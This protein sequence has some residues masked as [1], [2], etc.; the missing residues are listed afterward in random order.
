MLERVFL[1]YLEDQEKSIKERSGFTN[2]EKK[3]MLLSSETRTGLI[4]TSMS[5]LYV[6]HFYKVENI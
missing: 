6:S 1:K 5:L 4:I 3:W 2:E